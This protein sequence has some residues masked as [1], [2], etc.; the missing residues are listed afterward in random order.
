MLAST[1]QPWAKV[2]IDILKYSTKYI[3]PLMI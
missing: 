1:H 2:E 3:L